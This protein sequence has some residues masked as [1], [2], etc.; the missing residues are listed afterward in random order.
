MEKLYAGVMCAGGQGVE[1]SLRGPA[2]TTD[3]TPTSNTFDFTHA[4]PFLARERHDLISVP[5]FQFE[6]KATPRQENILSANLQQLAMDRDTH[7][8][9]HLKKPGIC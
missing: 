7:S 9:D 8:L 2:Y 3:K 1:R 6:I 5:K 4:E